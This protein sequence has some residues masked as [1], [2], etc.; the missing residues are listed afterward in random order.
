M[1]YSK[2]LYSTWIYYGPDRILFDA[3]ESVSSIMGNK[4]FAIQRVFLSHGH[5]DHIAGLVGLINIRNNAMGDKAKP[6]TVYY[7]EDNFH[8]CELMNYLHRTNGNLRYP[9]EWIP[10]QPGEKVFV[11][12]EKGERNARYVESFPTEHS[13]REVSLGYNVVEVRQRL[14]SNYRDLSQEEIKERVHEEGREKLME[15]YSQKIFSYG[16][17]SVPLDAKY[18]KDSEILYHD[19]TFLDEEDRKQFKHSTLEESIE[20]AK[21][22]GIRNELVAIHISSRY[23]QQVQDYQ[24]ELDKREDLPFEVTLLPPGRI[25]TRG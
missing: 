13:P 18:I 23:R 4:S 19:S 14:K 1:A 16:G 24:D 6:L 20:T 7:P 11:H 5:T 22:A 17:D 8:I 2:A 12:G 3:G 15:H 9:L 10:L 21:K 25:F